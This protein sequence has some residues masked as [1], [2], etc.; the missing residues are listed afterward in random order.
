MYRPLSFCTLKSHKISLALW[1]NCG[2][3]PRRPILNQLS[4][5]KQLEGA[6]GMARFTGGWIK[7]WRRAV[8]GDLADNMFLW[9]L[10]NWLLYSATWKP[11]SIIWKGRRRDIPPGT[12]VMGISELAEKWKCS[13]STIKKWL[14]YLVTSERISLETCSRGTLIT[15][16]NWDIYQAKDAEWREQSENE[17]GTE[18]EQGENEVGLNEEVK[19]VR[20]KESKKKNVG[21]RTEYP[22][23]FDQLWKLYDRRCDKKAAFEEY[24]KLNLGDPE[25]QDLEKAIRNYV[26]EAP[27]RAYR[28]HFHRFLKSDWRELI[29]PEVNKSTRRGIA[30]ILGE[31]PV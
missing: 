16:R 23:E 18:C 26:K 3:F 11:T 2:T 20:K 5:A 21:I 8:E 25:R 12:V 7:L 31:G 29:I 27:D 17:V 13:Q 24:K 1:E 6:S 15:I 4:L 19:K 10:W 14:T 30:E 22:Q 9:S 28:K